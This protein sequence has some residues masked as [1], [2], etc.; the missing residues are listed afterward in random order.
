MRTLLPVLERELRVAVRR[1]QTWR[2]RLAAAGGAI[3]FLLV[4]VWF[5]GRS[6]IK[7]SSGQVGAVVFHTVAGMTGIWALFLGCQKTADSLGRER[8]DG[9]LGL[10]FLTDLSGWDVIA[11]KLFAAAVDTVFQLVAVV[12][13]LIV[14]VLL[15]GVGLHQIGLL[16][17]ALANGLFLSLVSGLLASLL[18]RD[19]RQAAGLAV[20]W[21]LALLFIPW[22]AFAFLMSRDN[23][24]PQADAAWLLLAS[25]SLPFLGSFTSVPVIPFSRV[26]VA[27]AGA[28][29]LQMTLALA[30]MWLAARWVRIV[31]QEGGGP[32]W[33]WRWQQLASRIRF[34]SPVR[35]EAWRRT[36]LERG[37]W[38]W[39]S[40]RDVWKPW[41]PW[42]L[43]VAFFG[44]QAL[45]ISGV[46]VSGT[47][48]VASGLLSSVFHLLFTLWVAGE[49]AMTLSEHRLAGAFELLLTTGLNSSDIL[50]SQ[51]RVL[52][53]I[54]L[55]PIGGL[56]VF[57]ACVMLYLPWGQES[58]DSVA[59]GWWLHLTALVLTPL[60][61]W[62]IRWSSTRAVLD[63]RAV[64]VAV[65]LAMNSVYLL[66]AAACYGV[67]GG[68]ATLLTLDNHLSWAESLTLAFLPPLVLIAGW[69]LWWG[70]RQRAWVTT[71]FRDALTSR[72]DVPTSPTSA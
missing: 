64:N 67:F 17:L 70:T 4:V 24:I 50:R 58:W 49:A 69:C 62:A 60:Y 35:R 39:L 31:W 1:P 57:D 7:T 18:A 3:F 55:L 65:G 26:I 48:G 38:E 59:L 46:G 51:T 43:L 66:P 12:P 45:M 47:I 29:A 37:A 61:W 9:T 14:P 30:M 23:P 16:L 71:C 68:L 32:G 52:F 8:R 40:L 63:G 72:I 22:G 6:G 2:L 15:G 20:S 13:V 42:V 33:R 34:G 28:V 11:G 27:S 5:F 21:I 41:L 36:C 56:L 53:R 54:L 44:L 19:P 25:P 10:L